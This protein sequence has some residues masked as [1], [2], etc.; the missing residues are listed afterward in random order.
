MPLIAAL[1]SCEHHVWHTD[2]IVELVR[3]DA[4]ADLV[5]I[6]APTL[7]A[8]HAYDLAR[9]FR[10][11]GVPVVLGGP[12]AIALPEE[13]ARHADVV[14]VGEVEDT[15]LRVLDDARCGKLELVYVST[16]Q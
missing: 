9:E 13:V 1:T 14:V 5:G 6:T 7:S 2:E 10:R 16:R 4:L 8:L 3:F 12:H 15:W 11:R